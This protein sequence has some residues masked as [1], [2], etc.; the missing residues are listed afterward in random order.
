MQELLPVV[1]GMVAGATTL[2]FPRRL[3]RMVALALASGVIGFAV[4]A[5]SGELALRS[6][7]AAF[8]I[9]LVLAFCGGAIS[10]G[11][12]RVVHVR[13]RLWPRSAMRAIYDPDVP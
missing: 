4:A 12:P 8:A 6:P 7:L 5:L 9:D 1:L 3:P 2:R 13:Q 10:I 11:V